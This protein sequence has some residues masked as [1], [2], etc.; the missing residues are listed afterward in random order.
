MSLPGRQVISWINRLA[1]FSDLKMQ[2][3][4]AFSIATHPPYLFSCPDVLALCNEY[5]VIMRIGTKISFV[6]FENDKPSIAPES[7][8]GINYLAIGG[9]KNSIAKFT[10]D[11]YTILACYRIEACGNSAVDGWPGPPF[12]PL[13]RGFPFV[14][15]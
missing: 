14:G 10:S 13:L 7:T 6:V 15:G 4:S 5:A 12:Y 8:P 3:G 2:Y 11:I 9:C 1:V